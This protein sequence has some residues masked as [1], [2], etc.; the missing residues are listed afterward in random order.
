[1]YIDWYATLCHWSSYRLCHGHARAE[2]HSARW[3]TVRALCCYEEMRSL[4]CV[5]KLQHIP[6]LRV[7]KRAHPCGVVAVQ[8]FC[9][10]THAIDLGS[11]LACEPPQKSVCISSATA[12]RRGCGG[13]C[14][15]ALASSWTRRTRCSLPSCCIRN[16]PFWQHGKGSRHIDRIHVTISCSS[17]L[18]LLIEAFQS[19]TPQLLPPVYASLFP[20]SRVCLVKHQA[21]SHAISPKAI[22][23]YI[24]APCYPNEQTC[25]RIW[26]AVLLPAPADHGQT[27]PLALLA[28]GDCRYCAC[29]NLYSCFN[30]QET[31]M[32][33]V[34]P[35]RVVLPRHMLMLVPLFRLPLCRYIANKKTVLPVS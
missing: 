3:C 5:V 6:A 17:S 2:P 14:Y 21:E 8:L 29:A 12:S 1:M 18:L 19:V 13:F 35:R 10:N 20:V 9:V 27:A 32:H 34:W 23:R 28:P 30:C 33:C 15:L 31:T 11:E 26:F 22:E 16:K 7:G 4:R 24:P 25:G